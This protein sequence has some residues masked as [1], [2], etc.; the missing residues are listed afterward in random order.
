MF[1]LFFR[2]LHNLLK[3]LKILKMEGLCYNELVIQELT[4]KSTLGRKLRGLC[5]KS[6]CR[7][8]FL[9]CYCS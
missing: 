7:T 3:S 8:I 6:N 2:A 4:G 5:P 9:N 1:Y